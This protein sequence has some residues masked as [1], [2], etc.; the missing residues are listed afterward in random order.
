[1][2]KPRVSRRAAVNVML[3]VGVIAMAMI[4]YYDLRDKGPDIP[5]P[6]SFDA[7]AINR[8]T[9]HRPGFTT[10]VLGRSSATWRIESPISADA[11]PQRVE[12]LLTLDQL[13]P[14][15]SYSANELDLR[16]LGLGIPQA[17]LSLGN[18]DGSL[19]VLLG[20]LGPNNARRYIQIDQQVWLVDDIYLPLVQGGLRAFADLRLIPTS[21]EVTAVQQGEQDRLT[22]TETLAAWHSLEAAGIE[23]ANVE[24]R[25]QGERVTV[26]IADEAPLNFT[27]F[28]ANGEFALVAE[29]RDY[30]LLL[31]PQQAAQLGLTGA[32]EDA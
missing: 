8:V 7:A 2:S 20:G 25:G 24:Q 29:G 32:A 31:T 28:V 22:A 11:A 13:D 26:A 5:Q 16:E 1:M 14:D 4:T 21:A 30:A 10:I 3:Y 18:D 15:A 19:Q 12:A 6:T 17:T 9:L 27:L 23:P